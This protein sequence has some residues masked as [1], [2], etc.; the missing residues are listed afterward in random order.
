[1]KTCC[2]QK[3]KVFCSTPLPACLGFLRKPARLSEG[4]GCRQTPSTPAQSGE[5]CSGLDANTAT[6]ASHR[7][8]VRTSPP[9]PQELTA[10]SVG[11]LVTRAEP[12]GGDPAG[13]RADSLGLE[14][15]LFLEPHTPRQ[16]PLHSPPPTGRWRQQLPRQNILA[17]ESPPFTPCWSA[18]HLNLTSRN[19]QQTH[20]QGKKN[21]SGQQAGPA[22]GPGHSG[23]RPL[24]CPL[25]RGRGAVPMPTKM[26]HQ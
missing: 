26:P 8:P 25:T 16:P 9:S 17:H 15:V 19:E 20:V 2:S 12:R 5:P 13:D 24:F 18:Q 3:R 6:P 10:A 4:R 1:M 7:S 14:L 21:H 22:G 23:P 11:G